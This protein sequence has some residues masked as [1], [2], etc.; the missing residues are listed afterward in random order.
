MSENKRSEPTADVDPGLVAMF[1]KLTPEERLR[2]N[3]KALRAILE[4]RHAFQRQKNGR[5]GPERNS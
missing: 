1:L 5:S 2:A 3:D 4:L